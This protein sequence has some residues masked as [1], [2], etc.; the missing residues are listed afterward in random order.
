MVIKMTE[1]KPEGEDWIP[2]IKLSDVEGKHTGDPKEI[3]IAKH[4][5]R[6]K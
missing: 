1:A 3:E 4:I 5:L 6:I 2:A